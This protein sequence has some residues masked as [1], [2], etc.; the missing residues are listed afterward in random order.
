MSDAKRI[1][2][3]IRQSEMNDWVGGLDPEVIGDGCVRILDRYLAIDSSS[4]L[5]D[6]GCG[7]GRV[8]LSVLKHRPEVGRITGFDIVPQVIS[9]CDAHIASTFQQAK[10]ELIQGR[11]DHYDRFIA[12]VGATAAKSHS[13]LQSEYAS[14]FTGAYAFS[15]F[16]HMELSDFRSLLALLSNLLEPGGTLLFTAFLLTPYSRRS[17]QQRTTMFPFADAAFEEGGDIFIGN[18]AD[19]L[20]FIAFDLTLVQQMVLDVGLIM[21]HVEHGSWAGGNVY[22][23]PSL[24]DVIACRKAVAG[25]LRTTHR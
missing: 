24:Q 20:G 4:R 3:E 12:M 19:R 9:F 17:I 6:F 16:T 11:N 10:F 5:L 21:T 7:I 13:L 18:M 22:F 1:F 15:V 25:T 14:A 23:S 8:L 2:D